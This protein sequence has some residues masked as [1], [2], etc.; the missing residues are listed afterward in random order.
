MAGPDPRKHYDE[1]G[2]KNFIA[3]ARPL[4]PKGAKN[5]KLWSI[6][7]SQSS[8]LI[9]DGTGALL[10]EVNQRWHPWR[11]KYD[12]YLGKRQFAAVD[13]GLFAWEFVMRD[14]DGGVLALIDRNFQA[15]AA[16]PA[17]CHGVLAP[18]SFQPPLAD[19]PPKDSARFML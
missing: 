6:V 7:C 14:A 12:L 19:L 11:R 1:T 17:R 15:R 5:L 8:M 18:S 10:G 2:D 9:R 3:A 13:G 16:P 4:H